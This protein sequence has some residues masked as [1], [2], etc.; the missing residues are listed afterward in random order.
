VM[1]CMDFS[2]N[3][4]AI[5]KESGV[6]VAF[7]KVGATITTCSIHSDTISNVSLLKSYFV[8]ATASFLLLLKIVYVIGCLLALADN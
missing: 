3:G 8:L 2:V 4:L 7:R 6:L 1:N 5:E